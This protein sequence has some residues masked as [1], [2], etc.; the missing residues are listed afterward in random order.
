[1]NLI[2]AVS[3]LDATKQQWRRTKTEAATRTQDLNC[4]QALQMASWLTRIFLQED[5]S[6]LVLRWSE[7]YE[8]F[9]WR[10]CSAVVQF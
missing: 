6:D 4:F 5:I 8:I 9:W 3:L 2:C 10:S 7:W 1:M